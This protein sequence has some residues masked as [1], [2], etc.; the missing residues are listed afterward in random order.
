M[1][2]VECEMEFDLHS[3]A[4]RRAGGLAVHCPDCREE[5]EVKYL[6][7]AAGEG[8]QAAVQVLKFNSDRDRSAYQQF[9]HSTSGMT[10]GKQCQ[11]HYRRAEPAISFETK[12]TFTGNVNHK[13]K[14]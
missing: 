7:I 13:G 10:G 8:K 1:K 12:A 11:M 3:P 6:G 4:K 5:T 14:A 9:W 2:C